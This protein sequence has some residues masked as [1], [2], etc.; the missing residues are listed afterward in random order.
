MLAWAHLQKPGDRVTPVD[1]RKKLGPKHLVE[2]NHRASSAG[3]CRMRPLVWNSRRIYAVYVLYLRVS[4]LDIQINV[5]RTERLA[6]CCKMEWMCLK[7]II[8]SSVHI[9]LAKKHPGNPWGVIES[10][11]FANELSSGCQIGC[12][13]NGKSF[14][15]QAMR[16]TILS[17]TWRNR[18]FWNQLGVEKLNG[19][20]QKELRNPASKSFKVYVSLP[21]SR[22]M[23]VAPW[24]QRIWPLNLQQEHLQRNGLLSEELRRGFI[25][26]GKKEQNNH[27]DSLGRFAAGWTRDIQ[28][29]SMCKPYFG[30]KT[31]TR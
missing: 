26:C 18:A 13:W 24:A 1:I 6:R 17:T 11:A 5:A 29:V 27:V 28:H 4:V 23:L 19:L 15:S 3:F 30:G 22:M 12:F 21:S 31:D 7:F 2:L 14:L 16:C 8:V 9:G 20:T 25:L 10:S